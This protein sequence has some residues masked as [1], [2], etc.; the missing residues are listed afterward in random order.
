MTTK[1]IT[2]R[3]DPG[4]HSWLVDAA[5]RERRSI[6]AYI[7]F[8]LEQERA[9]ETLNGSRIDGGDPRSNDPSNLEIREQS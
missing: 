2:L 5:A 6:N 9:R 3:L 7:E 1:H 4:L 8:R